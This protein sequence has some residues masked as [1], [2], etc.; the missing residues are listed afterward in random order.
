[1]SKNE[2]S[3]IS[4]CNKCNEDECNHDDRFWIGVI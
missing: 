1:M 4:V 3:Y 2:S